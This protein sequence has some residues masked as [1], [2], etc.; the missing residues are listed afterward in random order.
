[1]SLAKRWSCHFL[2]LLEE[3]ASRGLF[4]HVQTEL[5]SR[6]VKRTGECSNLESGDRA[7]LGKYF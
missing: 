1:M 6:D 5:P 4:R 3:E 7:G 2:R